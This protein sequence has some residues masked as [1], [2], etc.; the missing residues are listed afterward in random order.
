MSTIL[1]S[2]HKGQVRDVSFT[3]IQ[4]YDS[5]PN[6]S[7]T[8]DPSNNITLRNTS[9]R[10][11]SDSINISP[12]KSNNEIMAI[13]TAQ[14]TKLEAIVGFMRDM[15]T[16]MSEMRK[17]MDFFS[18]KYDEL[19]HKYTILEQERKDDKK[20]IKTLEN[21]IEQME[22]TSKSATLEIK[23][24]PQ[25]KE[26]NKEHLVDIVRKTAAAVKISLEKNDIKNVYRVNTN[27]P[28]NKPIVAE[29]TSNLKKDE[30]LKAVK[31]YNR[32]YKEDK[33]NTNNLQLTCPKVAVYVT[34]CLTYKNRKLYAMARAFAKEHCFNY[35]WT[36]QGVVYLRKADGYPAL[37]I[38]DEGD[39]DRLAK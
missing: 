34:E 11:R 2:P 10:M 15:K 39:L 18:T 37:R 33:L 22:R 38:I 5:E 7:T 25:I 27:I 23:N 1:R 12:P 20:V 28:S 35:H 30:I 16:E 29:L 32:S 8:Q 3:N 17:S 36:A 13:M 21:K 4:H 26:E 31:T 24:I 6:L 19:H 9:K 14:D